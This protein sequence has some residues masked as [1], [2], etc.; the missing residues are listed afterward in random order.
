MLQIII[1]RVDVK[2]ETLNI[3]LFIARA[4]LDVNCV[5]DVLL[6]MS[7]RLKEKTYENKLHDGKSYL[8]SQIIL[9]EKY[10]YNPSV[11]IKEIYKISVDVLDYISLGL[12]NGVNISDDIKEKTKQIS[13]LVLSSA[14]RDALTLLT[15][16][17]IQFPDSWYNSLLTCLDKIKSSCNMSPLLARAGGCIVL[18]ER[19]PSV[20]INKNEGEISRKI[21]LNYTY[22]HFSDSIYLA[23]GLGKNV[24]FLSDGFEFMK[25]N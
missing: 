22:I 11:D 9:D 14:G 2:Q 23:R 13:N 24:K 21:C 12:L 16:L 15:N 19:V 1:K 18:D 20:Y 6:N 8:F 4:L 10:T 3:A 7:D 17:V 5:L 25:L